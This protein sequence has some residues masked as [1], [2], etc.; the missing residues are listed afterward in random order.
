MT[1]WRCARLPHVVTTDAEGDYIKSFPGRRRERR[2]SGKKVAGTI[3]AAILP[4]VMDVTELT[5][6]QGRMFTDAEDARAA[7]VVVLGHDTWQELF[8]DDPAVG[9]EDRD[10]VRTLH[11]DRSAG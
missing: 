1:L 2:Y 6:L 5:L 3:L 10:R 11:R 9:K 8:G 4:E 7:H